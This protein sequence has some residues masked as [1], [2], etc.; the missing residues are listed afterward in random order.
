MSD[1]ELVP[2][3]AE[4]RRRQD[5]RD[6]GAPRLLIVAP[7]APPPEIE[8]PMEDWIRLPVNDEDV[9]ARVRTL[10]RRAERLGRGTPVLDEDGVLH[11][12]GRSVVL[13]PVE[14]R[15]AGEMLTRIGSVVPRDVLTAAGWP[16][17]DPNRNLLD[18]RILRL[19]RRVESLGLAVTTVRHRG[20]LLEMADAS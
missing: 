7:Q 8:D 14:A 13:P 9:R 16:G 11:R 4:D 5:L 1:V 19:R 10:A 20:Y 3:P 12:G 6:A 18:V 15:L 2:W 17:E